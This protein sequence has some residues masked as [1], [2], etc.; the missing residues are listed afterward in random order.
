MLE[1]DELH[2][3]DN[4]SNNISYVTPLLHATNSHRK[5]QQFYFYTFMFGINKHFKIS[6]IKYGCMLYYSR[7]QFYR[8]I[9]NIG[10]HSIKM[11]G[12]MARRIWY[13][14]GGIRFII[15]ND[16]VLRFCSN[17]E[18]N[19]QNLQK[20]SKFFNLI[21]LKKNANKQQRNIFRQK[22]LFLHA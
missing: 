19:V 21:F 22:A 10:N 15:I 17:R 6:R 16:I 12:L 4:K 2:T 11:F 13:I 18:R 1:L 8:D 9:L 3:K 20:S 5:P 14:S 7:F